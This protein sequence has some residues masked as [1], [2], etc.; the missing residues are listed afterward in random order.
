[1]AD[2]HGAHQTSLVRVVSLVEDFCKTPVAPVGYM[3]SQ[4]LDVSIRVATTVHGRGTPI[5]NQNSRLVTVTGNEA[6]VGGGLRSGVNVGY[7][8]PV[9]GLAANVRAEGRP[10]VRHHTM[11]EMNCAGPDGPC[12]TVGIVYYLAASHAETSHADQVGSGG[13]FNTGRPDRAPDDY[14]DGPDGKRIP[15]YKTDDLGDPP[16]DYLGGVYRCDDKGPYI[17]VNSKLPSVQQ[18]EE[19]DHEY[20]HAA[21]DYENDFKYNGELGD[22]WD[23]EIKA[24]EQ[25]MKAI[26]ADKDKYESEEKWR[27]E[28]GKRQRVLDALKT[29]TARDIDGII[30]LLSYREQ[31]FAWETRNNSKSKHHAGAQH[32]GYKP[33]PSPTPSPTAASTPAP[34]PRLDA[35]EQ[36]LGIQRKG[37]L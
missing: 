30:V 2:K 3:I 32:A 18:S 25:Q 15:V 29:Y 22:P 33:D 5:L 7:C 28:L 24:R 20:S 17:K 37:P 27:E 9:R 34:N 8:R 11:M 10:I 16:T 1:M 14:K 35:I 31:L 13:K 26:L 36:K 6:G 19:L 21:D 23:S 12:N 4:T